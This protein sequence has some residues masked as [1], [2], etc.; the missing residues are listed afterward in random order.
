MFV[1]Q[2]NAGLG[3]GTSVLSDRVSV[4][5]SEQPVPVLVMQRERI[6]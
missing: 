1:I 2:F 5:E 6:A 3:S 4:V